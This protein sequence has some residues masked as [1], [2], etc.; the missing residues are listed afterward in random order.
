MYLKW[1]RIYLLINVVINLEQIMAQ[2]HFINNCL[3]FLKIFV[4][5]LFQE[6]VILSLFITKKKIFFIK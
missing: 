2:N 5:F 6:K 4:L 1:I 3:L